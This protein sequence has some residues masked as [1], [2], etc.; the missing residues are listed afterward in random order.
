MV[1]A[2]ALEQCIDLLQPGARRCTIVGLGQTRQ[3]GQGFEADR[4]QW[5]FGADR[6][7]LERPEV[8]KP[9]CGPGQQW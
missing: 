9:P 1:A 5:L 7:L 6:L 3:L 4:V 2:Q 8:A